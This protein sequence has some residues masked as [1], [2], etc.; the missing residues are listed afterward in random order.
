MLEISSGATF[1]ICSAL[2]FEQRAFRRS[3]SGVRSEQRLR[4]AFLEEFW[5]ES[6]QRELRRRLEFGSY[7][8]SDGSFAGYFK[9]LAS[10]A[11]HLSS[12]MD[13]RSLVQAIGAHFPV[14]V[15]ARLA[16]VYSV[17][18]AVSLLRE[19]EL[20][21]SRRQFTPRA[22]EEPRPAPGRFQRDARPPFNRAPREHPRLAHLGVEECDYPLP[23]REEDATEEFSGNEASAPIAR[24]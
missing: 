16:G 8:A 20:L 4:R 17:S 22:T 9:K 7:K 13:E 14:H 19:L 12:Y 18:E 11:R 21:S 5:G 24:R 6:R 1:P 3:T 23:S 15:A 10:E 2:N